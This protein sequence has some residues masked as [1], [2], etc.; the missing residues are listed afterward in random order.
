MS[1]R[2]EIKQIFCLNTLLF[3]GKYDLKHVEKCR[4]VHLIRLEIFW[5]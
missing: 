2:I 5:Y 4:H 3:R 1:K